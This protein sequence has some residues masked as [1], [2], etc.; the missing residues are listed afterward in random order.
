MEQIG[1][2]FERLFETI[3]DLAKDV[4]AARG[5]AAKF[6]ARA[7]ADELLPPAFLSDPIIQSLAGGSILDDARALLS[8]KHSAEKLEHCW[9]RNRGCV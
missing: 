5:M 9:V 8:L 3:D 4:P 2:G 7:V 1:K 6:L